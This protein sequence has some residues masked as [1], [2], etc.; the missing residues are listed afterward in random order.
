MNATVKIVKKRANHFIAQNTQ[1]LAP[2]KTIE[3]KEVVNLNQSD[4]TNKIRVVRITTVP[5]SLDKLLN[6]QLNYVNNYFEVIAVSSDEAYL[7]K[8]GE[9]EKIKVKNIE[10]SRKITPIQDF[11]S[12]LKM[13]RFLKEIK[14]EIV[15]T[16]TPKAGLVGMIA[17][18]LSGVP[19][20]MHTI[21]GLPLVEA[22]GLK[23]KLLILC[24]SITYSCATHVYANSFNILKIIKS[25][26][27]FSFKIKVLGNG[28]TNGIDLKQFDPKS[29]FLNSKLAYRN[30][31][32]IDANDF[33]F[34]FVGRV[35]SDK[36]INELVR[37]F[38]K[39]EN[40]NNQFKLL[41]VGPFEEDLNPLQHETLTQIK[42]NTNIITTGYQSDVRKFYKLS[43][44]FVF[45][46][47]REGFPNVVMEAGAMELP[48]IT[49]N[50]NGCDEIIIPEINGLLIPQKNEKS[51]LDAMQKIS[52]EQELYQKLK[53]NSRSVIA[54]KF[55][56][57]NLWKIIVNEYKSLSKRYFNR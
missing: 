37:A 29:E 41:L 42:T 26:F 23:K 22:K 54:E 11:I 7:K 44:V 47:Y 35:V 49:T 12:I 21:S 32:G 51:L 16:H 53:Q 27:P 52:S 20:R 8:I 46:S 48:V 4:N 5:L 14:P 36:G 24:E 33:V 9:K 13:Y 2:I 57:A 43:D 39:L 40:P 31:Y 18:K 25:L 28:S 6:G 55:D 19:V 1:P 15:H 10:M 50:I 38:S 34:L 45:P 17:S 3:Q 56:Q 30:E